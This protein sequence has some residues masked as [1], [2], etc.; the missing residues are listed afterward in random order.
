MRSATCKND[1]PA[2]LHFLITSPDPYFSSPYLSD[3]FK[4]L[5]IL[6]RIIQKVSVDCCMQEC[7]C[8]LLHARMTT[9]HVFLAHLNQRLIVQAGSVVRPSTMSND[10]SSETT[11][12]IATKFHI[13]PPGPLGK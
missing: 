6:G 5:N 11:G 3:H 9:L 2:F 1:N 8:G 4:Y 13:Q 7:Q 10:F 12:R